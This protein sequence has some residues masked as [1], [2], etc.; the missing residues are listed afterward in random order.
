MFVK[1]LPDEAG[2]LFIYPEPRQIS[3][4]MKNTF[5]PLDMIFIRADGRVAGISAD[6]KPQSLAII[7][8]TESVVAVLEL[9]GGSAARLN[10]RKGA[11]AMHS[12]FGSSATK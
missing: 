6:A 10:I 4:W 12:F 11:I 7:E 8:S 9:K 5:I 2:M 3:M 1:D